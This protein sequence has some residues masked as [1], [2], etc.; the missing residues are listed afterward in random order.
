MSDKQTLIAELLDD[1]NNPWAYVE[2]WLRHA[3]LYDAFME[4]EDLI[5][6]QKILDV[7]S[8]AKGW[9]SVAPDLDEEGF[10]GE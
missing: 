3:G 5:Q 1:T 4:G 7:F 8:L 10:A 9:E 2:A 6:V